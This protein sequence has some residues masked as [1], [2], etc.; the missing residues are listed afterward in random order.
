LLGGTGLALATTAARLGRARLEVLK[1]GGYSYRHTLRTG[2]Q[3]TLATGKI[4]LT[5]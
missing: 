5:R 4:R 2:D 1:A 3:V